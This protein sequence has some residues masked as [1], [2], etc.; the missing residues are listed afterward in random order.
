MGGLGRWLDYEGLVGQVARSQLPQCPSTCW[1][2]E[3]VLVEHQGLPKPA[4]TQVEY[5]LPVNISMASILFWTVELDCACEKAN[6]EFCHCFLSLMGILYSMYHDVW[7]G[8]HTWPGAE[9]HWKELRSVFELDHGSVAVTWLW[10]THPARSNAWHRTHNVQCRQYLSRY[11][12]IQHFSTTEERM[13]VLVFGGD[14]IIFF[15]WQYPL[16]Y[17]SSNTIYNVLTSSRR[18]TSL[19]PDTA[20]DKLSCPGLSHRG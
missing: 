1:S 20:S 11:C 15:I 6:K 12:Q 3:S 9:L 16:Y 2:E 10:C 14:S 5:F 4:F 17:P 8:T 7:R 19:D 18:G 13:D